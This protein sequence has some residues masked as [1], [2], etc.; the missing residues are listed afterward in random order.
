MVSLMF[1]PQGWDDYLYWQTHDKRFSRKI[2]QLIQEVMRSPFSGTGKPEPLKNNWAGWWSR[3]I[4]NTHRF[5]YKIDGNV[6]VIAQC[7]THYGA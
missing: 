5:V 4:D 2:N 1:L 7:R 6:L 3:R